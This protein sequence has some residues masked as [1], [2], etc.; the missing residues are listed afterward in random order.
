MVAL[1]ILYAG[2]KHD[3][4]FPGTPLP[5]DPP[6][7]D[8]TECD[9][10]QVTYNGSVLRIFQKNCLGC[11]NSLNA[12][13]G[14]DLKNFDHLAKI[15]NNG[16]LVGAINHTSG[17]YPMPKGS[18]KLSDCDI[19]IIEI[20]AA[21][22]TLAVEECD[23]T[24]IT[25][26][27]TVFPILKAKCLECHSGDAPGGNLDFNNYDHVAFIAESGALMGAIN[28]ELGYEPMPKDG[29]KL[30]DCSIDQIGIWIRDT[31]F[32]DPGG[33]D[34]K[35]CDP[36][37]VYFENQILPL[38]L[39]SCATTDCHDKLTDEQEILL[40]DYASIIEYGDIRPG[41]PDEGDF[42]EKIKK[43][44][45]DDRMPPPP[46]SPLT[47]EQIALLEKWVSQGAKNNYCDEACDTTNVTFSEHVW[48]TIETYCF[49]CHSGPQ[50][51]GGISLVDYNAVVVQANN[52]N[53]FGA[54][55]HEAGYKPMPKNAPK[56]SECKIDQVKIWI[57]DGTPNN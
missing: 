10:L 39:S 47:N 28:H 38:V 23:T 41:E 31:T 15:I 53:L 35:P 40:V 34:D 56:L 19:R 14:I 11:H 33:G 2:C 8:P 5:P 4:D 42:M 12:A 37:S 57:E 49:G 16:S 46:L 6:D 51:N 9:T 54:I 24:N 25:Y 18:A 21:D 27:G 44:D 48:P 43:T 36:D 26:N 50:P 17:F 20:W 30:D 52:G 1:S 22:T 32:T 3:P 13:Y 29:G 7:P 55:N 45:P